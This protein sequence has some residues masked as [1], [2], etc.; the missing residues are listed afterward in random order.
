MSMT[1]DAACLQVGME[2]RADDGGLVFE[3]AA[4]ECSARALRWK[5]LQDYETTAVI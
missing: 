1:V 2:R 4:F 3:K 5:I